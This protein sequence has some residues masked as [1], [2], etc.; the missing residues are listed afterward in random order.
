[1][2]VS[3]ILEKIKRTPERYLCGASLLNY[4]TENKGH[5]SR[6][7]SDERTRAVVRESEAQANVVHR[8][9]EYLSS[10]ENQELLKYK[11]ENHVWT[12]QEIAKFLH[13]FQ[14]YGYGPNSNKKIA[15]EIGSVHPNHVANL[16][17]VYKK[18]RSGQQKSLA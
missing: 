16:K 2:L 3:Y 14:K 7:P 1:M 15:L 5:I 12:K 10:K 8:Y 6:L 11:A 9:R 18:L 4:L 13:A 17:E